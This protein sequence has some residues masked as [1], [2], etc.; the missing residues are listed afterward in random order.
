MPVSA[1]SY[2]KSPRAPADRR[3]AATATT[4]PPDAP[5]TTRSERR[6]QHTRERLLDAALTVFLARGYDGATTGEMARVADLG[7]GTFYCHFRDKRAAFDGVAQRASRTMLARWHAALRPDM[8]LRDAVAVGLDISAAFWREH[9]GRARL[10]LEGG[11]S[12][13]NSA[14]L[15][16]VDE[17]AS[18]L[19]ARFREPVGATT[20]ARALAAF[21][22]GLGIEIGRVVIGER[23]HATTAVVA[24]MIEL[25]RRSVEDAR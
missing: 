23:R 20:R 12:F 4:S 11:P 14:H 10:L 15:R 25:A 9:P 3:R 18:T 7:T 19:R 16:L 5:P 24:R 2:G 13:G 6:K 1:R 21:V 8:R 22:A 17:L